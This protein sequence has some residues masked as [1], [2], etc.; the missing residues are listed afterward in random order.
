MLK[1]NLYKINSTLKS[2]LSPPNLK[3]R[4][5]VFTDMMS[6][7][8]CIS[9]VLHGVGVSQPCRTLGSHG[10]SREGGTVTLKEDF[11]GERKLL[12]GEP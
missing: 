9:V 3:N 4:K 12:L 2:K 5:D 7:L 8:E 1:L 6:F 10:I 11:L